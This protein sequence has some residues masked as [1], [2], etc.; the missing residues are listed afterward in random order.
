M[1]FPRRLQPPWVYDGVELLIQNSPILR[2][3]I[4]I[5]QI[6]PKKFIVAPDRADQVQLWRGS[7]CTCPIKPIPQIRFWIEIF[8]YLRAVDE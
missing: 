3:T 4:V 2:E 5:S 7:T 1:V 8:V 6:F